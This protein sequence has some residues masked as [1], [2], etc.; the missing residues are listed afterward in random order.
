MLKRI[1]EWQHNHAASEGKKK[2]KKSKKE[3]EGGQQAES[4]PD[5]VEQPAFKKVIFLE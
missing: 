3:E 1:Q 5:E 4:K 2:R